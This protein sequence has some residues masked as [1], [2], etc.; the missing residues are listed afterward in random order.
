MDIGIKDDHI[1]KGITKIES[2]ARLQEIKSGKLKDL[3]K[4][5]K[6]IVDGSHNVHGAQVLN[7]YLQTLNC[8]KHIIL[9][10]M[11]NKEHE[12]Y[13]SYFKDISSITTIDIPN[14][15]SISGKELKNKFKNHPN[16]QYQPEYRTSY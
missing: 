11:A 9:G 15:N 2:I 5:N 12:K 14:Q 16:V 6:L 3:V 8:N 7:E 4:N 1:K 10:M 13:I